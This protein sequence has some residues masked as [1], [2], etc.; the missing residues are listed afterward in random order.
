MSSRHIMPAATPIL[1]RRHI[2]LRAFGLRITDAR[3][4]SFS[5]AASTD[6][7]ILIYTGTAVFIIINS[8]QSSASG[9]YECGIISA[10]SEGIGQDIPYFQPC[11]AGKF[12]DKPGLGYRL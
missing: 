8:I 6:A 3:F 10:E 9:K 4:S 12:G 1:T 5:E 7:A 11:P 2:L